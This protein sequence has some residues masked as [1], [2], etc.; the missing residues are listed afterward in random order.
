[1][2]QKCPLVCAYSVVINDWSDGGKWR[3]VPEM[4]LWSVDKVCKHFFF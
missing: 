2:H 3:K 4:Q 1:M